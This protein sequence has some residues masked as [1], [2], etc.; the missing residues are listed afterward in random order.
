MD[1]CVNRNDLI[2]VIVP[3]YNMEQYMERCVN[4]IINQTYHN[5]EII[6]VDDG[7]TDHST[8]MCD[9]Y[10]LRDERI[11]VVHKP[12]GGLSDARNAGLAVVSGNYVGYVDSDDWI[13]PQMYEKMYAACVEN[14]AQVAVCRYAK[15]YQDRIERGGNGRITAF[16]R[17][18]ILK[19]YLS[20]TDEYVV[21]NSVWSKL[22]A[23]E[24]VEG[25]LFPVGKNSEDIMYTTRA[26]CKL[27]R[28]VYI[29]ECLYNYVLDR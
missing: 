19:V 7:S 8:A 17:E 20:D 27:E 5:L 26:F 15:A 3:V 2:S 10:A 4:S 18:G 24:V 21:Y 28:A 22:F 1:K 11:K 25:V 9:E 12:N 14:N 13:E 6:L 16:D 23:R 29:D